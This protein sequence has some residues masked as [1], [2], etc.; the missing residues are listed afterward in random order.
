MVR[1]FF[2]LFGP[3]S[4][5]FE[6]D[7]EGLGAWIF[8]VLRTSLEAR[9]LP[10]D[11]MAPLRSGAAPQ[12]GGRGGGRSASEVKRSRVSGPGLRRAIRSTKK[13]FC[14]SALVPLR[15]GFSW[16]CGD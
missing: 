11:E 4:C 8:K 13:T 7:S 14:F 6:V 10:L 16:V 15:S 12:G 3:F 5:R 9:C 2:L 1:R